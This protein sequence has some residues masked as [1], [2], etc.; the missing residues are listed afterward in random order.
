MSRPRPISLS[1]GGLR[2]GESPYV[3]VRYRL[4]DFQEVLFG[5][6][7]EVTYEAQDATRVPK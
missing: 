1:V 7:G 4:S 2:A 6:V 3:D 5:P